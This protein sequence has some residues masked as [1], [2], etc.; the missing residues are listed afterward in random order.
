MRYFGALLD[1]A[2]S[3]R[4]QGRAEARKMLADAPG[5]LDRLVTLLADSRQAQR[6]GAAEW[7]GARGDEA[8][9]KPLKARLKKEK[10]ELAKAAILTAL[11]R[12][13]ADTT[14][15]VGPAALLKEAE[16]GLKKVKPEKLD[17]LDLG[18]MPKLHYAKGKPVPAEVITWWLQLAIK[19]KQ[20]GGNTLFEIYLD[21]LESESSEALSGWIFES[22]VAFDTSPTLGR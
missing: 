22:W 5:L 1:A 7:M 14:D 12:L 19:L 3:E 20:P 8:A 18:T 13:G 10:S 4:K 2:T 6:A 16:A 21:Q 9:I 17:W 15:F 11:N